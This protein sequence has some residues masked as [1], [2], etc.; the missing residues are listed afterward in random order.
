ME[1]IFHTQAALR[2]QLG[3]QKIKAVPNGNYRPN[4]TKS[5]VYLMNKFGFQPTKPGPYFQ[6]NRFKQRGLAGSSVPAGGR[7]YTDTRLVKTDLA[8]AQTGEVTAEDQQNDSLYLCEVEI[9]TPPQKLRLDF[10]TGSAD[11]WVRLS[12]AHQPTP[13]EHVDSCSSGF[14][15]PS[16]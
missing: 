5:Y 12:R 4:G 6:Q 10:D 8:G 14:L 3:L 2:R 7:V 16:R 9:G 15:H 13:V 11:L 1:A